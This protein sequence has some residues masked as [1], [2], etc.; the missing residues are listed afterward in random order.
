VGLRQGDTLRRNQSPRA[1][2]EQAPIPIHS[3]SVLHSASTE[4]AA[5]PAAATKV[6]VALGVNNTGSKRKQPF[7]SKTIQ[8][9]VPI[10]LAAASGDADNWRI[11]PGLPYGVK[12][13]RV[14]SAVVSEQ[15]GGSTAAV[16]RRPKRPRT[17]MTI[18]LEY[19]GHPAD[20]FD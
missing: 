19:F 14:L 20:F 10:A 9:A 15:S 3:T 18:M 5:P 4:A 8:R 12:G 2:S 13:G 7:G 16:D 11:G 1:P 6:S 17:G